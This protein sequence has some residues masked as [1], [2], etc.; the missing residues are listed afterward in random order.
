MKLFV[1]P[2][3]IFDNNMAIDSYHLMFKSGD[4]LI[5]GDQSPT[6]LDGIINPKLLEI[7]DDLGIETL[8]LGKP[9]FLPISNITLLGDFHK[10]FKSQPS[11]IVLNIDASV[12]GTKVYLEKL[13]LCKS[14]GYKLAFKL[15]LHFEDNSSLLSLMDYIVVDQST[16]NK[17]EAIALLS[18]YSSCIAVAS[19]VTTYNIFNL[20]KATGYDLFEGRF[21]RVPITA[22]KI[23]Q[24]S[25][26]KV[27]SVQ[28]LNAV[29][30]DNFELDEIS[31][32]VEKDVALTVLLLKHI[33]SQRFATKIKTIQHAAAMLGQKELRKWVSTAASA[34]LASDKPSEISKVSLIRAKF[35][36]NLAPHFGMKLEADALFLMGLFSV[37]DV[38]LDLSID[39]ALTMVSVSD[40]IKDAL[41]KHTGSYYPI[42]EFIQ[43]Y[44]AADWTSVSRFLILYGIAV[45][46]IYEAYIDSVK[47]YKDLIT[48]IIEGS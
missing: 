36:E 39:E 10:H 11:S 5:I 48:S 37:I 34:Q 28:L 45:E 32:I 26:L 25:P 40:N 1:V 17:K 2:V 21:Y 23:Q 42:Y 29:R 16:A 22:G 44:E 18:K 4:N 19:S 31:K 9:I 7:I 15:P 20:A 8:T 46:D 14:L 47:W 3:P 27:L 13:E 30:E 6:M 41:V 12:T 43:F 33:N 35:G 38:M 24:V